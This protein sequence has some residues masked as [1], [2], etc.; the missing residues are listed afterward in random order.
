M[1]K[2][3][4][5]RAKLIAD[6]RVIL[7]SV[8]DETPEAEA[9]EKEARFDALMGDADKMLERIEREERQATAEA[10]LDNA[11]DRGVDGGETRVAAS[12]RVHGTDAAGDKRKK[13]ARAFENW[14]RYGM[15]GLSGEQRAIMLERQFVPSTEQRAQGTDVDSAGGF[16][17]PEDFMAELETA[18]LTFGG[19]R[20]VARVIT[21]STGATLPWPTSD[22]TSEAGEIVGE[23]L[24]HNEQDVVFGSVP[25]TA[26]MYSSKI[27][28]ISQQLLQDSAFDMNTYLPAR[29]G[30]RIGR[31]TNTHFTVGTGTAQPRGVTID[32]VAQAAAGNAAVTHD[33]LLDLKHKVDPAYRVGA[34]F[35]LNDITLLGLKKLKDG[36]LRPLWQAGIAVGEP[37]RIDGDPYTINQDIANIAAL[38]IS[39]MYGDFSKYI[40][41]DVLNIQMLR[42]VERYA[43]FLQVGFLGFSRHDG[44]MVDA[45]T[46]PIAALTHPA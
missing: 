1:P 37:D 13:E 19:M 28:R 43:E 35:M 15:G 21:T 20:Q 45:G 24:A 4:E 18:L 40:I 8:T 36:D 32:G 26:Y 12:D 10:T 39:V 31:I 2:L 46:G 11:I 44:R 23:N 25:L 41:R 22:D 27:I 9:V 14:I 30:E 42:L 17:V 29:L 16:T 33:D 7:D 3:R 38:A 34:S 6:A 5:E